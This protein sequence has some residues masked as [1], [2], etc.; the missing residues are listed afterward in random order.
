MSI[1][2]GMITP[3]YGTAYINSRD[4]RYH[5][6]ET[7]ASIGICPQHNILFDELTVEEHFKFFCRL[8]GFEDCQQIANEANRYITML[9]MEDK[10]DC[11]TK[12]LSGGTKRKL[13]VG[14]ALCGNSKI[15]ILDEPTSGMD[16]ASRRLLWNILIEEKEKRTILFT[17]HLLDEA[18]IL[19]DRIAI[20]ADG[21]LKTVGSSFF[22]KKRFG[23][24]YKL[25]CEKGYDCDPFRVLDLLR[26]FVPDARMESDSFSEVIYNV[27]EENLP[28][29]R[30]IFKALE[31]NSDELDII[32]FGCSLTTLEEVFLKIGSDAFDASTRDSLNDDNVFED[33]TSIDFDRMVPSSRVTG[34]SLLIYQ[35]EATILKKFCYLRRNYAPIIWYGFLSALL[36]FTYLAE[37]IVEFVEPESLYVSLDS[38]KD[39][40]TLLEIETSGEDDS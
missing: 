36:I 35:F 1:L 31:D 32:S 23:T 16:S 37:P 27:S 9:E 33:A 20:M 24:G 26:E 40:K 11:Q 15:V 21:E 7:R 39:T 38:Y 25:I 14:I 29:F 30:E 5:M 34:F 2:T 12:F 3:S 10:R 13:S 6:D 17:T 19:G 22:L 4:I 8:K 28:K 18:D